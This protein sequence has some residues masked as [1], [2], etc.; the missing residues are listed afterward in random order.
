MTTRRGFLRSIPT[1]LL[2]LPALARGRPGRAGVW[3]GAV[4]AQGA[5]L[6]VL[7]G[8]AGLDVSLELLEGNVRLQERAATSAGDGVATFVLTGLPPRT[9]VRYRVRVADGPALQGGFRTF[10]EGPFSFRAAFASC[11]AT[12]SAS[13]VFEAIRRQQPDLFVHLGDLH[14]EDIARDDPDRFR[15]AYE[16][17]LSSP[18]QAALFRSAAVAYTWDDHDYGPNDSDRTSPSRHAALQAYRR[19]VPHYPLDPD[20]EA[21]VH[22]AFDVG[23][24]R[25]L[26]T[27]VRSARSPRHLPEER[28]TLLGERQLAWLEGQLD[29]ARDAPLVVWVNPVPW[30]TRRDEST[31]EGWAPYSRERQRLADAVVRLGLAPRLVMLSGDA[32]MLALDDG[33]HSQYA[34]VP[35]APER[36]FVVAHAAPLDRRPTVKGGPYSH[37]PATG[38]GQYGLMDVT[39]DGRELRVVLQGL[40][41]HVPVP[42]L[43]LELRPGQ[44]AGGP[45]QE[46]ISFPLRAGESGRPDARDSEVK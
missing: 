35:G 1:G 16:R 10:A 34:G 13:P 3:C 24:V 8:R 43:R 22:Q 45:G 26:L 5:T 11:A 2:T 36:A 12:G 21:T 31:R 42:G 25:F 32:H 7:P 14:Y 23:R 38:N 39:D 40:R 33:R 37:P 17:V 18:T 30:I 20:T 41:G 6:K 46:P 27:D 19:C 15:S 4:T 9:P 28:R 44:A 29:A